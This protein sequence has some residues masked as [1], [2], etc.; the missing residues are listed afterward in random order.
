MKKETQKEC[1]GDGPALLR[2]RDREESEKKTQSSPV[3]FGNTIMIPKTL[4]K[5]LWAP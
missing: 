4:C 5:S 1:A 3:L 2:A